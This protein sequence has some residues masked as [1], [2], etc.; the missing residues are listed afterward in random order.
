MQRHGSQRSSCRVCGGGN[1][2]FT[3]TFLKDS[4]LQSFCLFLSHSLDK[5]Q[6]MTTFIQG[7][8]VR[9]PS[10]KVCERG[11]G[12]HDCFQCR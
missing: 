5:R 3:G 7:S 1:E 2:D 12:C 10:V 8:A 4:Q 9:Q 11:T 6:R